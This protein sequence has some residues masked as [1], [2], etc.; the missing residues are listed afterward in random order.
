[1]KRL[2][3]MEPVLTSKIITDDQ[4]IHQIK[5]DGIRGITYLHKDNLKDAHLQ[6]FTKSG[7]E[8]T[9]FY[10]EIQDI[11]TLF[12]GNQA[13]LDGEIVVFNPEGKPSFH[14]ALHRDQLQ[15]K[16]KI[17]LYMKEYPAHYVVFDLLFLNGKDLR[18]LPLKQ[19]KTILRSHLD[20]NARI[21]ISEDFTDGV[22]LYQ[23]MK[24][25]NL[26]GIVSKKHSSMYLAG[27]KHAVWF[28]TKVMKKVLTV[29]GGVSL[30]SGFPHSL[31]L[32]IYTSNHT[33]HFVGKASSGLTQYDF[34][35]LRDYSSS[36]L[37]EQSPFTPKSK[38]KDVLWYKP[39]LTC[40]VSFLDWTDHKHLRH[41]KILGFSDEAAFSANGKEFTA[42]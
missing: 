18:Q 35:L 3:V 27:K 29:V 31:L 22:K 13:I 16:Q 39:L 40:W 7:R 32:G 20:T 25:K 26:E 24:E 21:G 17:P 23:Q 6:V 12:Q 9:S 4:W 8:R 15:T 38:I 14:L 11:I 41:P 5:W 34:N 28:K 10:P 19:R 37:Q 36:L 30:K 42:P 33:L 2:P 1:M